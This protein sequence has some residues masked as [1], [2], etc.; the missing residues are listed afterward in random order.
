[1]FFDVTHPRPIASEHA[2]KVHGLG[3]GKMISRVRRNHPSCCRW[4]A[5]VF[6]SNVTTIAVLAQPKHTSR[7]AESALAVFHGGDRRIKGVQPV[8]LA[9]SPD[10]QSVVA[11]QELTHRSG[12]LKRFG[13][14]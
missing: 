3:N 1:M 10:E 6:V 11:K 9:L 12:S 4:Q 13:G 14:K 5:I 7:V 2:K 8:A